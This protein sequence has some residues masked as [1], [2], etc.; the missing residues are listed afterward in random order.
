MCLH[1]FVFVSGAHAGQQY[2][3]NMVW[4]YTHEVCVSVFVQRRVHLRQLLDMI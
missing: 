4:E 1:V 3:L 2:L